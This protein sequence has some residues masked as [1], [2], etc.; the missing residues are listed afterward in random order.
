M[1][2]SDI[3]TYQAPALLLQQDT[4]RMLLEPIARTAPGA[5]GVVDLYLMPA[6]DD[7]ATLYFADGKWQLHYTFPDPREAPTLHP[8]KRK[9]SLRKPSPK[10]WR[11]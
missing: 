5:D 6:Y 3:G 8:Q 1:E 2:D 10:F 11:P 4:L 9:S 7:I